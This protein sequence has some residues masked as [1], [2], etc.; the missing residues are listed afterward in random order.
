MRREGLEPA[1]AGLDAAHA[2]RLTLPFIQCEFVHAM[3][4]GPG[5]MQEYWDLFEQYPRLAGGFVWEWVEQGIAVTGDDGVRRIMIG[6]DF[7]EKVHD[8]NF[9]I[10]GLVSPDRE[11]RPGLIHYAATIAQVQIRVDASRVTATIENRFDHVDLAGVALVAE[12]IVDGETV[13]RI[14]LDTPQ[15]A[16]RHAAEIALPAELSDP[17]ESAVADVVTVRA[18]TAHDAS[19]AEAGH[20]ISSGQDVRLAAPATPVPA[21]GSVDVSTGSGELASVGGLAIESGPSVGIWRAPTDNDWGR[22][23][24]EEDPTPYAERW[25]RGG[26]DRTVSRVVSSATEG[27]SLHLHTRTGVPILDAAIDARM[28]W[29]PLEGGSVRLDLEIEPDGSWPVEWARLGLDF[30]I[31]AAPTG[32]E[33]VGDGPVTAYPDMRAAARFGWWSLAADEIT[34]DSIT[35][36]ESGARQGV[37]DATVGTEVGSLR[38]RALD[39]PFAL[40]VSPHSRDELAA[41]THNWELE[42]DGK[43]HVSIDLLQSGVGTASCGPGALPRYRAAARAIRTSLILEGIAR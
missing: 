20:E 21:D 29:T 26:Y 38:I 15:V 37:I 39:E 3:G 14:A 32:L 7:G 36:Q 24:G 30:V 16:P 23:H 41:K 8:G 19:W 10:D 31:D 12:R 28:T 35:P 13:A 42:A 2:R 5:G 43:T 1:A 11:P 17:R 18:L 40:T 4:T 9:V 33:F 6:G 22:L 27:A 34:V 25:R